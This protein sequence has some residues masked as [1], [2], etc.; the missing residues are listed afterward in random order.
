VTEGIIRQDSSRRQCF[1]SD[2]LDAVDASFATAQNRLF[3]FCL[4]RPPKKD[5]VG[6]FLPSQSA[7]AEAWRRC[8]YLYHGATARGPF[9]DNPDRPVRLVVI[10]LG[11]PL[12]AAFLKEPLDVAFVAIKQGGTIRIGTLPA[13][14]V[15]DFF[16]LLSGNFVSVTSINL[17]KRNCAASDLSRI[18]TNSFGSKEGDDPASAALAS[19]VIITQLRPDAQTAAAQLLTNSF[20]LIPLTLSSLLSARVWLGP[21]GLGRFRRKRRSRAGTGQWFMRTME[22]NRLRRR[23]PGAAPKAN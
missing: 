1:S 7:I 9:V 11:H 5:R 16:S 3:Q 12:P 15:K 4:D 18:R 17:E 13:E 22:S 2:N 19:G 8:S 20:R 21:K 10:C 23:L 6:F 14:R